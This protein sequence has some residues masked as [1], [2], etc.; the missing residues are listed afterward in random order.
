MAVRNRL[1][2]WFPPTSGFPVSG[3]LVT[4]G[5]AIA[6]SRQQSHV[7]ERVERVRWGQ[8]VW[9]GVW[10][11]AFSQLNSFEIHFR[12]PFFYGSEPLQTE[13]TW[14]GDFIDRKWTHVDQIKTVNFDTVLFR[15]RLHRCIEFVC[16]I[17]GGRGRRG[18]ISSFSLIKNVNHFEMFVCLRIDLRLVIK[19]RF[20]SFPRV[21]LGKK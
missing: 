19:S 2:R 17:W 20:V 14:V 13:S 18:L 11:V 1:R 5:L 16:R 15:F 9:E 10:G 8:G 6:S 4:S 7:T 12:F 21:T 3:R